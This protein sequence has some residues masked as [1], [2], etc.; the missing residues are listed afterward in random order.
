MNKEK[1]KKLGILHF[2][3]MAVSIPTILA[4]IYYGLYASDVYISESKFSIFTEENTT[5]NEGSGL[6]SL[7][8]GGNLLT[9]RD[10][11]SVREYISSPDM[12]KV[13]DKEL[14]L[15]TIFRSEK[16]D[17]FSKLPNNVT[18]EDFLNYYLNMISMD[19]NPE[20]A[21]LTLKARAFTPKD[22]KALGDAISTKSDEFINKILEEVRS[23]A[24]R[25]ALTELKK[26]EA[27]VEIVMEKI[28]AFKK[29]NKNFD[30]DSSSKGLL[31]I[32]QSLQAKK[33]EFNAELAAKSRIY[34]SDH[35][36]ITTLISKI[37]SLA[38]EINKLQGSLIGKSSDLSDLTLSFE[39][40]Q[41]QKDFVAKRYEIALL[42]YQE[43]IKIANKKTK[44]IVPISSPQLPSK[45]L[46]PRR[47][48]IIISVFFL[49]CFIVSL[50]LLL[51]ASIRDHVQK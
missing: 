16:A 13:L 51:F 17:L 22:A 40:L 20:S 50:L 10:L 45:P 44:Y 9:V 32:I 4:A 2:F 21:I 23:D 12:L 3:I 26:A 41:T 18:D 35:F 6:A 15:K 43:A 39:R 25:F 42:S 46:E 1:K 7:V 29:E 34:A 48:Y 38:G 47:L 33:T 31:N 5:L 11:L 30:P 19:L 8:G 28:N 37:N 27:D 24:L 14:N 49:S 36:E